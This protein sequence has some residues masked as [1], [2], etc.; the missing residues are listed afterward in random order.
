L[1]KQRHGIL[2]TAVFEKLSRLKLVRRSLLTGGEAETALICVNP[3]L[4]F[5]SL[6]AL[7]VLR[8]SVI[9]S[10]LLSCQKKI[11]VSSVVKIFVFSCFFVPISLSCF[12][13]RYPVQKIFVPLC[14]SGEKFPVNL[15]NF[16]DIRP[17]NSIRSTLILQSSPNLPSCLN[18]LNFYFYLFTFYFPNPYP[19]Y[20]TTCKLNYP[21]CHLAHLNKYAYKIQEN[22][23]NFGLNQAIF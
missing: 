12:V 22:G 2:G 23:G 7:R 16:Y 18:F 17:T 14:L 4:K 5:L 20:A 11:S 10:I 19:L 6:R 1:K 15:G 21:F 13:S 9:F 8:G 3:C